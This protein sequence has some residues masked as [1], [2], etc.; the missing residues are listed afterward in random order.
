MSEKDLIN[1]NK[2]KSINNRQL[3][4]VEFN[5]SFLFM[6]KTSVSFL[7]GVL[8]V[9]FIIKLLE[10]IIPKNKYYKIITLI[11]YFIIIIFVLFL[12]TLLI[13][14]YE[15]IIKQNEKLKEIIK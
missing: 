14:D 1:V 6:I 2:F 12:S 7:V 11:S 15:I 13:T 3:F 5:Q 8:S 9:N 10:L 4:N